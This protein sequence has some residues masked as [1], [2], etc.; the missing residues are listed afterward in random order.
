M[1]STKIIFG[2]VAAT[3]QVS[4]K[5]IAKTTCRSHAARIPAEA[6][7]LPPARPPFARTLSKPVLRAHEGGPPPPAAPASPPPQ[8]RTITPCAPQPTDTASLPPTAV[9]PLPSPHGSRDL[10]PQ[11]EQHGAPCRRGRQP[12]RWWHGS[13]R[14]SEGARHAT[15]GVVSSLQ[16]DSLICS[17][18]MPSQLQIHCKNNLPQPPG[19][20]SGGGG[21]PGA[22]PAHVRPDPLEACPEG[23]RRGPSPYTH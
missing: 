21:N 10:S 6:V 12:D 13:H 22:G 4:Y 1:P 16:K 11:P 19:P 9:P 2:F 3:C 8:P 17:C 15:R 7:I 14:R 20:H 18:N 5:S 23:T